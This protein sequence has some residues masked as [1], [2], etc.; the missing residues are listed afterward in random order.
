MTNRVIFIAIIVYDAEY[1][2]VGVRMDD[3]ASVVF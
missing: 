3:D 1:S 2:F